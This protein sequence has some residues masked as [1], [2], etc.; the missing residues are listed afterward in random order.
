MARVSGLSN[1]PDSCEK[2]GPG[3]IPMEVTA[4]MIEIEAAD[5]RMPAQLC[6]PVAAGPYPGVVVVMEAFG[7]NDHIKDVARRLAVEGFVTLAP[8]LYYREAERIV[9]YDVLPAAI[10]LMTGLRDDG[11]LADMQAAIACLTT[12][13]AVRGSR[14]GITGFCM[15]GRISFLTACRSASVAAAVPVYGGGIVSGERSEHRPVPPIELASQLRCPVLAY[16]GAADPFIPMA[17]VERIR[18]TLAALGPQHEVVVYDGAAH[19]FFC[20][21]RE[22][23]R[24]DAAADAWARTM[25]FLR[26]HLG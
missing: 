8:D 3:G 7:L 4:R 26:A 25:R 14:V 22:S 23:Y 6:D 9:A 16:F 17:D 12:N 1:L 15:G 21:E 18:D 11:V 2:P 19:G 5:G 24:A 10:R 20:D 13:A